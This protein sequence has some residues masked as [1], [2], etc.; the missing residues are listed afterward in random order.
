MNRP[1]FQLMFAAAGVLLLAGSLTAQQTPAAPPAQGA[2][3]QGRQ[4]G[5]AG[6]GRA[7]GAPAGFQNLTVLPRDMPQPQF[8]AMMQG[9]EV[10]LGVT[11]EH[12]HVYFGRG[13]MNDFA[14]DAKQ[15]KKTARL[16]MLAARDFNAKLTPADL[17][18]PAANI[19]AVA[20]GTCHRGKAIPDYVQPQVQDLGGPPP[21]RGGGVPPAGGRQGGN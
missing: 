7:G 12:C 8:I 16:M 4:G 20:C 3:G 18:K 14:S 21:T 17:G 10:A 19:T 9:F 1:S 13:A 15:A 5:A 6:G 2:A 11:C